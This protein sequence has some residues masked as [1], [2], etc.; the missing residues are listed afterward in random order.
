[1][2]SPD[3]TDPNDLREWLE[4]GDRP[5]HLA[6][7]LFG[8]TRTSKSDPS[9]S[10]A[11]GLAAVPVETLDLDL[12][13]PAQRVFGDY[14][15]LERLGRGGMG[16]VYR[17][18]Q[19][20]L[21]RDVA[22][23]LLAAG[24][25]AGRDFIDRLRSEARHAARLA[26]PH[27][28]SVFDVGQFDAFC[29]YTMRLVEGE[30]L[31]ER[32]LRDGTMSQSAAVH[33]ALR[34]AEALAYAHEIGVLHLD[35]KPAN[36]LLD[37]DDEPHL[38]DFGLAQPFDFIADE[39]RNEISGT[40]QYMAPEQ[41]HASQHA[42]SAATDIFALGA[43]LF[44]MLSG[45]PPLGEGS[46]REILH[47]LRHAPMPRLR[48]VM[49]RANHEL[50]AICARCLAREPA[51]RYAS[52]CALADDL[53]RLQNHRPLRAMR[54]QWPYRVRK[55]LRRNRLTS[56]LTGAIFAIVAIAMVAMALQMRQTAREAER[57]LQIKD[58]LIELFLQPEDPQFGTGRK[59]VTEFLDQGAV[60]LQSLPLGSGV[61]G[62]L[63]GVLVGIYCQLGQWQTA[64]TLAEKELGGAPVTADTAAR[65][66]LRLVTGWAQANYGLG[67]VDGISKPLASAI[68]H[69]SETRSKIYLDALV[70]QNNIAIALGDF[71]DAV[72]GGELALALMQGRGVSKATIA[73]AHMELAAAYV[74]IRQPRKG[75][76]HSEIAL[77]VM[78]SADS[79]NHVQTTTMAGLRRALFGEFES[80]QTIFEDGAAQWKRLSMSLPLN[81][82]SISYA[83]NA[84]DLGDLDRSAT[85]IKD[86]ATQSRIAYPA[87]FESFEWHWLP[88]E[89]A[90]HRG[91]YRQAG[92][93]FAQGAG[94]A[95]RGE[96]RFAPI[97]VY[98][99]AL[100]SVAL[101]H[102]GKLAE[103]QRILEVAQRDGAALPHADFATSMTIAAKAMLLSHQKH[104]REA[105]QTF[106][107]AL[108][109]LEAGRKQ[110]AVLEDQLRENR[111]AL[112]Y[113]VWKAQA[114]IDAGELDA[115]AA[116]LSAA[117]KLGMATLGPQHPFMRE[118]DAVEAQL[119][120]NR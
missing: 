120:P 102:E 100:Q 95:Q 107:Q 4:R 85:L 99:L 29:F 62:E 8:S 26:H 50:D 68:A 52:A 105:L 19:L 5:R 78:G 35:I 70:M 79:V 7:W 87:S 59:S 49:P 72:R 64:E 17:A 56:A 61:R 101:T 116:T 43:T 84:F 114:Q 3:D 13:D 21:Y 54:D 14:E 16:V 89:I 90:F 106:D 37:S 31:R 83:T 71:A 110:P 63:A 11:R 58:Q 23:K 39:A 33:I 34:I 44:E 41:A 115:A 25:W 96:S 73:N 32:L 42:V 45:R 2:Q 66:D 81:F 109:E 67:R 108:A 10:Q 30:S 97:G 48:D 46:P 117:R 22:L 111:D 86:A 27:I 36:I 40:P 75:R 55:F 82:H 24:P 74:G 51:Q 28:V 65:A 53:R 93:Q 60:R 104:H 76:E 12:T 38:A 91:N 15:L 94:L 18:R 118:L 92:E 9:L 88:G 57:N 103:A 113:R 69:S 98:L 47:E 119:Q 112:R 1:M 20:S 6:A 80:A 77:L